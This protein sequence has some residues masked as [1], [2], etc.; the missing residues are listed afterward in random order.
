MLWKKKFLEF[1]KSVSVEK[2]FELSKKLENRKPL[3]FTIF[4]VHWLEKFK[5]KGI[6]KYYDLIEKILV[7]WDK[8]RT[9]NNGAVYVFWKNNLKIEILF[10]SELNGRRN[11]FLKNSGWIF[12]YPTG[13]DDDKYFNLF[14]RISIRGLGTLY[15]PIILNFDEETENLNFYFLWTSI[16]RFFIENKKLIKDGI[17]FSKNEKIFEKISNKF[18]SEKEFSF[19]K[20]YSE[21]FFAYKIFEKY[22]PEMFE[23]YRNFYRIFKVKW[24][25]EFDPSLYKNWNKFGESGK[26]K[27]RGGKKD[28]K[29]KTLF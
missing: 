2:L 11:G 19:D 12:V 20:A 1:E 17:E 13:Y 10:L 26:E 16:E 8:F 21:E 22:F 9:F 24:I 28:V 23:N 7:T 27:I 4:F 14:K 29:G 5:S 3:T 18:F 6:K 15:R 25:K